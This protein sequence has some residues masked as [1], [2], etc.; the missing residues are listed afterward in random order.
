MTTTVDT[1]L[2]A[3]LLAASTV[4]A[5]A[6]LDGSAPLLCAVTATVSCDAQ[7]EC[8][9]GPAEA[10]NL[11]VFLKIDVQKKVAQSVRAGGEQRTSEILSTHKEEGSL[12]LLGVDQGAGWSTTIGE[13][14]GRLTLSVSG[15]GIGYIAFGACI[16]Q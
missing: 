13:S 4:T 1:L 6:A 10:V 9:E 15:G 11:P 14:D 3:A 8:V 7:G 12:V 2:G 16:P 5:A